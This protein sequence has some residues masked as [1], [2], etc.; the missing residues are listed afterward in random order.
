M[1]GCVYHC[2]PAVSHDVSNSYKSTL[3]LFD[4]KYFVAILYFFPPHFKLVSCVIIISQHPNTAPL[5]RAAP[6]TR[7]RRRLAGGAGGAWGGRCA[8]LRC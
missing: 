5:R 7:G 8:A 3:S 2:T 6:G 1:V 4:S